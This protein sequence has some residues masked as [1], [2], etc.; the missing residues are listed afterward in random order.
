MGILAAIAAVLAVFI[1][2]AVGLLGGG[3]SILTT[4]LLIYVAGF[5]PKEA[6]TASLFVVAITSIF[7][8]ISHARAGRVIWKTGVLFGVA[9]MV[10]AFIGGQ[11]GARLPGVV[12]LIAFAIMMGVTAVA[13][14]RGRKQVAGK[15]HGGRPIVRILIDGLVVGLVTGLVG[16]GGGFLVVPALVLL[17]GLAMPNA[18]ATSLLVVAMKS[19]AGFFG[20]ALSFGGGSIVQWNP[21]IQLDWPI[22]LIVTGAAIIG[23]LI[24]SRLVGLIHPDLLRKIFGWFVLVMAVFILVQEIGEW[25]LEFASSG[26]LQTIEVIVALVAIIALFT[27]V[28][29]RPVQVAVAD[30]DEPIPDDSSN[31]SKT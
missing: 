18:V 5:D 26:P 29:R 9:G 30:F 7:G 14:I 10:G 21:E 12:L 19:I 31:Q 15:S 2:M 16:A 25:V 28:I 24:G 13:M 20:Y 1:G 17:G 27:W 6:I 3:G 11:I 8:L 4:P 23:A 22:I